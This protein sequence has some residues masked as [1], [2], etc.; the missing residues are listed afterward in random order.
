[1]AKRDDIRKVADIANEGSKYNNLKT[2]T[3]NLQERF[4]DTTHNDNPYDDAIQYLQKKIEDVIDESNLQGTASQSYADELKTLT[5]ASGSFATVS[6]SF[7]TTS[8]SLSTRVTT[9][10]AK[11]SSPFPALTTKQSKVTVAISS[12]QHIPGESNDTLNITLTITDSKGLK[13]QKTFVLT[14]G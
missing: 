2:K 13:T 7:S 3:T 9:N 11:V 10:D 8:G 4:D 14:S 1:M 6:G 12:L 5:S